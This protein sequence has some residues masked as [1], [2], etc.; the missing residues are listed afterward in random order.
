MLNSKTIGTLVRET[1]ENPMRLRNLTRNPNVTRAEVHNIV[2]R[3]M[4]PCDCA[5]RRS[6]ERLPM[7]TTG[8]NNVSCRVICDHS[9]STF[10]ASTLTKTPPLVP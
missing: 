4:T 7:M 6:E 2:T 1:E 9:H 3:R 10:S 5:D 8:L